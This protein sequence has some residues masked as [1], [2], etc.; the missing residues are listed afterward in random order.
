MG[1]VICASFVARTASAN[2]NG[3]NDQKPNCHWLKTNLILGITFSFRTENHETNEADS[4]IN[5]WAFV[6]RPNQNSVLQ[7]DQELIEIQS[8]SNEVIEN[9]M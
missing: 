5:F 1:I 8:I 3:Q 4:D 2:E 9:Y 6:R 7:P